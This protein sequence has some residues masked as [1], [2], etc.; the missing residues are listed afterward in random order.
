MSMASLE[1]AILEGAR[2]VF[3]NPKLRKKDIVEWS[4]GA[5]MAQAG[6]TVVGVPDLGVYVAVKTEHDKRLPPAAGG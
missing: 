2:V 4:S 6:E 5:I 3:C 1:K